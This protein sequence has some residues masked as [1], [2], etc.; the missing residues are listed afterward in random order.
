M[1]GIL[2]IGEEIK[3][4]KFKLANVIHRNKK[5]SFFTSVMIE[6]FS[7]S[8]DFNDKSINDIKILS[9]CKNRL[10]PECLKELHSQLNQNFN[11][12]RLLFIVNNEK[13]VIVPTTHK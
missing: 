10:S 1:V 5:G 12:T 7:Y 13:K 6:N 2:E 4:C 9:S 8:I 3:M 11:E